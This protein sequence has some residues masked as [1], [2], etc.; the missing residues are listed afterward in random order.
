MIFLLYYCIHPGIL[1]RQFSLLE[2]YIE[3]FHISQTKHSIPTLIWKKAFLSSKVTEERV[4][5]TSPD[6]KRT[7]SE[8][9]SSDS[10]EKDDTLV[11]N[12]TIKTNA[13]QH[14]EH[15]TIMHS[16][17]QQETEKKTPIIKVIAPNIIEKEIKSSDVKV[18]LENVKEQSL[19]NVV[20]LNSESIKQLKE[21][22]LE[23]KSKETEQGKQFTFTYIITFD[24]IRIYKIKFDIAVIGDMSR[25]G[26]CRTFFVLRKVSVP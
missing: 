6:S 25:I 11:T 26:R 21:K 4:K 7:L 8:K 5:S 10:I 12:Q 3:V 19:D 22:L 20:L 16:I 24:L 17:E 14:I 13:T 2:G 18:N 1:K 15:A 23:I 9:N